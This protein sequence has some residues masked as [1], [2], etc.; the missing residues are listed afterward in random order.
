M[1]MNWFWLTIVYLVFLTTAQ[2]INKKSLNHIDI[3][4]IVF[5]ASVQVSTCIVSFI[6]ALFTGWNF[7]FNSVSIPLLIGMGTTYFFAVSL[8]YT[9]LKKTELS[10]ASILESTGSIYSLIL[11]VLLLHESFVIQKLFGIIL[12]IVAVLIVSIKNK[13]RSFNKYSWIILISIFFYAL[14]AVFDKT[15]NT[16]GNPLSYLTL[17]FATAGISMLLIYFKRTKK[18]FKETFRNKNFW[19]GIFTNGLLYSFGFWALFEA[20]NR[21]GEVSKMF[22]ITL[23]MSVLIPIFGIIFLKE[24][25]NVIK[26]LI[27]V[28]VMVFGLWILGR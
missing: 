23:S 6:L 16:Y 19:I 5:G 17:S 4:E 7:N 12:I 13:V 24:R 15:L 22:P 26:K 21:G 3:D 9:G 20:Y 8:Y 1:R 10:L 27:A 28:V 2:L 11:G 18:A 14:G 25:D